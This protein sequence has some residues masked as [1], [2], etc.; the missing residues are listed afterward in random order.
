MSTYG[1]SR[2]YSVPYP[3]VQQT[4]VRTYYNSSGTPY[5]VIPS[6]RTLTGDRITETC[7]DATHPG[8]PYRSGGP[9]NIHKVRTNQFLHTVPFYVRK[10]IR[11]YEGAFASGFNLGNWN[12]SA[13]EEDFGDIDSFGAGAW[14]R[15]R[16]G[17]PCADLGV[18]I[19]EL[20]EVIPMLRGTARFFSQLWRSMGGRRSGFGPKSVADAWLN[21]QFGWIP[22]IND[23]FDLKHGLSTLDKMLAQTKRDNG[24]WIR[25]RGTV[26]SHEDEAVLVDKRRSASGL[27]PVLPT[28][29]YSSSD[30][31]HYRIKR[32]IT[33][34]VW[35]SGAFRYWIPN[36]DSPWV[37]L[38]T[39]LKYL[40]IYVSPSLI[41]ELTPWSWLV[42]WVS[43][44]GDVIS[45]MDNGYVDHLVAKYAYLMGTTKSRVT[46]EATANLV[47][48]PVSAS[49][50]HEVERKCRVHANPFGFGLTDDDL[51]A[52]QWSILGALGI[53]RLR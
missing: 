38:K 10:G 34:K 41:W 12:T 7:L 29:M 50:F 27:S 25:R 35:F 45:N 3:E 18:A 15:F 33:Q 37:G 28:S 8:P 47:S 44:A 9:M 22:F 21:T 48:G 13:F 39:K 5:S 6:Y 17:R 42:D 2:T 52:R 11:S 19:A 53:T 23:M 36:I 49:F 1:R 26:Y 46:L 4:Y 20:R 14:N 24:R 51:S 40:G 16:P 32:K 30:Y 43:N 31:G